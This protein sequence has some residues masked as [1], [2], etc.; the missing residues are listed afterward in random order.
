MWEGMVQNI[1]GQT[2]SP[3]S[4]KLDKIVERLFFVNHSIK[5]K[6]S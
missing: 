1:I 6:Q 3:P 4:K 5:I 2:V